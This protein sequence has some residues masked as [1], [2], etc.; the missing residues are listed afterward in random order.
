[1]LLQFTCK[2]TAS[3]VV[4]DKVSFKST[5]TTDDRDALSSGVVGENGRVESISRT[6][7]GSIMCR[8]SS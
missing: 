5:K 7:S 3:K 4:V 2:P 6:N 8:M 1:M